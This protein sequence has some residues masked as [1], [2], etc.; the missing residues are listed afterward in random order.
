MRASRDLNSA[1]GGA[2]LWM[3][4][5]TCGVSPSPAL[6]ARRLSPWETAATDSPENFRDQPL[7][8]SCSHRQE[9]N[10]RLQGPG[11]FWGPVDPRR[12]TV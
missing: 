3:A 9:L 7:A 11:S 12:W 2:R 4:Q 8:G 6:R 10:A 1:S 5:L